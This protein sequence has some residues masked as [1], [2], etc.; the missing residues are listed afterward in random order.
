MLWWRDW[1]VLTQLVSIRSN[2]V[3]LIDMKLSGPG[4][5]LY[6]VFSILMHAYDVALPLLNLLDPFLPTVK[7]KRASNTLRVF[8]LYDI[9]S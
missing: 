9:P 8:D 7:R 2:V 5:A 3:C 4:Y 6:N 1:R